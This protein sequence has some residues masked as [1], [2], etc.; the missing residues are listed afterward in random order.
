MS[1]NYQ[2]LIWAFVAIVWGQLLIE[3]GQ[4]IVP[5]P[6]EYM[7]LFRTLAV[8]ISYVLNAHTPNI[9]FKKSDG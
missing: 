4:G 6:I 9:R 7:W 5:I 8:G 3:V 2:G 1:K